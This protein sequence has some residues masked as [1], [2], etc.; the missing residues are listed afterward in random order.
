MEQPESQD[1]CK[2]AVSYCGLRDRKY[3]DARPMGYPFDRRARGGVETLA[4]FLTGNM[5]VTQITIRHTDTVLPRMRSGSMSNTLTFAWIWWLTDRLTDRSHVPP[6]RN[7]VAS[8]LLCIPAILQYPSEIATDCG[9]GRGTEGAQET[10]FNLVYILGRWMPEWRDE[11][12]REKPEVG[13]N[14]ISIFS[15]RKII[16]RIFSLRRNTQ[17]CTQK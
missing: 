5:A 16:R 9:G 17:S 1:A 6:Q 15:W 2:D 12:E 8:D 11:N 4:Q 10:W 3:P 7:S 13:R 14:A